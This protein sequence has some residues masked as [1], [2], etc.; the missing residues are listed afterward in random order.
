MRAASTKGESGAKRGNEKEG[1][2]PDIARDKNQIN[3][4]FP[5]TDDPERISRAFYRATKGNP[6]F[7]YVTL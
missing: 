2:E 5:D 4:V 3:L 1:A 7:T 6:S